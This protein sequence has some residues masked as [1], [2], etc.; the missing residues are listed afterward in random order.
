MSTYEKVLSIWYT[1]A[2]GLAA[3]TSLGQKHLRKREERRAHREFLENMAILNNVMNLRDDAKTWLMDHPPQN[4][5][6]EV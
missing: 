1:I 4:P 5:D 3:L 6:R 2:L